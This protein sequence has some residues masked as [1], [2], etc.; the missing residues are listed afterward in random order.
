M[1]KILLFT[2]DLVH[3]TGTVS[4]GFIF[5]D[6]NFQA[7]ENYPKHMESPY[8]GMFNDAAANDNQIPFNIF[9]TGSGLFMA[10]PITNNDPERNKKILSEFP[11]YVYML[12]TSAAA[13]RIKANLQGLDVEIEILHSDKILTSSN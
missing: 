1:K 6:D 13:Q 9:K 4:W 8:W 7:F 10:G 12:C 2:S 11:E 3:N 5:Q